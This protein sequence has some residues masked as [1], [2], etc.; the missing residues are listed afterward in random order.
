M[1]ARHEAPTKAFKLLKRFSHK[2][3]TKTMR[4]DVSKYYLLAEVVN[5]LLTFSIVL[6]SRREKFS[7]KRLDLSL[8]QSK[9][10]W[11]RDVE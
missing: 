10:D 1:I 9:G 2:I 8:V 7:P 3:E 6:E 4:P 11:L 5:N